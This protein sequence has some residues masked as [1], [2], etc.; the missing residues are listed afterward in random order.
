[1]AKKKSTTIQSELRESAHKI[2]LA[3][4]GALAVAEDEGSKVFQNL[5][6]RG[7]G[8]EGRGKKQL[9]KLQDRFGGTVEQAKD[10]AEATWDK[11]GD[12]FDERVAGTLSKLGVPNRV[13]IQR[14]TKRVE[15]LTAKVDKLVAKPRSRT[16]RARKSA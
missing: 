4:L 2:W 7:E 11:L 15:E 13:E 1:M 9:Q 8:F 6:E 16:T 3:G 5:V 12:G 10:K 14:L